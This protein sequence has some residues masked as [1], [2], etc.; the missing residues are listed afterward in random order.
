MGPTMATKAVIRL[1]TALEKDE[2]ISGGMGD[3]P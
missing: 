1:S 3:A 2:D